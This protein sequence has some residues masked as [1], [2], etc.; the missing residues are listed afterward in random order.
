M[1]DVFISYSRKD[2]AFARL[3]NKALEESEL[4]TWIDWQ[5]IPPSADWLAEVY[6]AIEAADTFIFV[7]SADSVGSDICQL[8]IAHAEKNNK[9]LVPIV[10]NEVDPGSV[11]PTLAA[12]NWIFFNEGD[13]FQ[14]AVQALIEAIQTDQVWVKQHTRLQIRALDWERHEWEKGY[15]LHG[16]DLVQAE[17]WLA[18]AAEKDPRPTALQTQYILA[19]RQAAT[20]RQRLTLIAVGA[21]LVIAI[22]LGILAWTQRN[23]AVS[24]GSMRAT[25]QAAAVS[26]A[27]ARATAQNIAEAASTEAVAQRNEAVHQA[28]LARSGFFTAESF[29]HLEDNLDLATLLSIE[30][31]NNADTLQARG[32]L[33]SALQFYPQ[34]DRYLHGHAG[35]VGAVAFS[36]DGEILATAGCA[37]EDPISKSCSEGEILL[38]NIPEGNLV[39]RLDAVHTGFMSDLAF[40]PDGSLLASSSW[41]GVIVLWDTTTWQL[42][43]EP[44]ITESTGRLPGIEFYPDGKTLVSSHETS[45]P[46]PVSGTTQIGA[47]IRFWDTATGELVDRVP[48]IGHMAF[49]SLEFNPD[50]ETFVAAIN[51]GPVVRLWDAEKRE[52]IPGSFTDY[53]AVPHSLAFSPDGS[54][55]ALGN[56]DGSI[57]FWDMED[58][59]QIGEPLQAHSS[60]VT[61]LVYSP[62]GSILASGSEDR[63]IKLWDTQSGEMLTEPLHGHNENI[64]SLAFHPGGGMLV[65]GADDHKVIL[66][67]LSQDSL[68]SE[69]LN[70]HSGTVWSVVYSPDGSQLASAGVDGTIIVRDLS[71]E[72]GDMVLRGHEGQIYALDF[73]PLG[74][75]LASGGQYGKVFLWDASTGEQIGPPLSGP[76][77]PVISLAFS[78]GGETLAAG[79]MDTTITLWDV[80]S[81]EMKGES[82]DQHPGMVTNLVFNPVDGTLASTSC[83][84]PD[85]SYCNQGEIG[86]WDISGKEITGRTFPGHTHYIYGLD[87][88]PDGTLL[89]TGSAD[90][91]ILLW[92]AA[93]GEVLGEPIEWHSEGVGSLAFSPD[94]EILASGSWD[95]TIILMDIAS[96]QV[97]GQ[98]LSGHSDLVNSL[99]WRR[100]G[101]QLASASYDSKVILWDLDPESWR[102]KACRRA[103]RNLTQAEWVIYYPGEEYRPTCSIYE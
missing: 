38:W 58:D 34:L 40:S 12:L 67:N 83:T 59:V 95:Q 101:K 33:L 8:E 88:S 54:T 43:A 46:D 37:Q 27:Q 30:A 82:I 87:F 50:G 78:P 99:A 64:S 17:T 7:I 81:G 102:N 20:R 45:L 84:H 10:V 93:N 24:E 71:L 86:L 16:G 66:W 90:K 44:I 75:L 92:D 22:G 18:Q 69:T 1:S 97:I 2:I 65:S 60:R 70:D 68:I 47:E 96:R 48:F 100:D 26:E 11:H 103:G 32:S 4:D 36:P 6:E 5:D 56:Y 13:P 74:N 57:I 80:A 19:S 98:P 15:L 25:A 41:G 3:L 14:P 89:A 94:G 21:G 35:N 51:S 62:D 79:S 63:T 76:T 55:L 73:G 53:A 28:Q 52:I 61:S 72:E 49:T 31:I 77:G 39:R 85:E 42:I 29:S 91:T 9:R 23:Q